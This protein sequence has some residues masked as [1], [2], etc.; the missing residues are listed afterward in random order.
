MD[1]VNLTQSFGNMDI[2]GR[3]G[4]CPV[5]GCYCARGSEHP[6]WETDQALRAHID[7]HLLGT[8]RG[9][10]P[11]VWMR[12]HGWVV[13]PWCHKAAAASRRGGIHE[14]CAAAMRLAA[15]SHRDEWSHLDDSWEEG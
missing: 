11:E 7:A 5:R 14:S 12:E 9:E 3:G 4:H 15:C 8:L 10:V 13:C 2:R 6:G 1:A